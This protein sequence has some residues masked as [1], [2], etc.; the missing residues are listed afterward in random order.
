MNVAM[1]GKA[2]RLVPRLSK[3]EW[4]N[5]DIISRWLI[6]ARAAILAL[7]FI[8]AFI[9]GLLAARSEQFDIV[10]WL[11]W[12]VGLVM[13][14]ATNNMLNDLTDHWRGVE[15]GHNLRSQY[16]PQPLADGLMSVPELLTY[17]MVTGLLA[18]AAGI[19][20][21]FA[22]GGLGLLLIG[23]AV[24]FV[25]LYVNPPWRLDLSEV[26]VLTVWGPLMIGGGYYM[27]TGQWQW[28]VVWT[29]LP[30]GLRVTTVILGKHI[31][32]LPA[33][34][35]QGL[36]TI[37]VWL[38]ERRSALLGLGLMG[39]QYLV[40]VLLVAAG[41][42]TV[43]LLL[44]VVGLLALRQVAAVYRQPRPGSPPAD[45]PADTWPLWYAAFAFYHNRRFTLLF[46][47][48]LVVDLAL[49]YLV[50]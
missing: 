26:A 35:A 32:R 42:F 2:I 30:V 5:L 49:H 21:V 47:A 14:H 31:Y 12:L 34:R 20:L 50:L 9:A 18:V 28:P 23:L 15:E 29:S 1:W 6:A 19:Y 27:I 37:P 39:L 40:T 8:P 41:Y 25:M 44:V 22:R 16:G 11:V 13:A 45:Y 43:A 33:D 3:E 17:A 46:V 48:G 4:A 24:V 7:T 38:G 10:L 36:R